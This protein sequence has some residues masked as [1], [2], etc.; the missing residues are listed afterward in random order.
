MSARA[1]AFAGAEIVR[2]AVEPVERVEPEL[3]LAPL[4]ERGAGLGADL[5]RR[6]QH[7]GHLQPIGTITRG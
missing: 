7:V 5:G 4:E 6:G 1:T 3:D 2:Q